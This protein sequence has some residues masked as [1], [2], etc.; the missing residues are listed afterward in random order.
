MTSTPPVMARQRPLGN[1]QMIGKSNSGATK[2]EDLKLTLLAPR[3]SLDDV[4]EHSVTL[5]T[6]RSRPGVVAGRPCP[7]RLRVDK[8]GRAPRMTTAVAITARRASRR[9]VTGLVASLRRSD[10]V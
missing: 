10:H 7:S 5:P 3:W 8:P 4:A 9:L 2:G 1:I 6:L